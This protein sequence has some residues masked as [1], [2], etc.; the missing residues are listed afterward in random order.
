MV[1]Y[2]RPRTYQELNQGNEKYE[3]RLSRSSP[4]SAHLNWIEPNN[5]ERLELFFAVGFSAQVVCLSPN[6][7]CSVT[8][9]IGP[10]LRWPGRNSLIFEHG[11]WFYRD[12]GPEVFFHFCA[13][14]S[15]GDF[16]FSQNFVNVHCWTKKYLHQLQSC[17]YYAAIRQVENELTWV[18][19]CRIRL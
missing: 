15:I 5:V 10:E 7:L 14:N 9:S 1:T 17:A 2:E 4:C 19:S 12:L 3:G 11:I 18:E 6:P 8:W 16:F 13:G